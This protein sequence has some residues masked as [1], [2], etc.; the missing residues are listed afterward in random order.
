[1]MAMKFDALNV[2]SYGVPL[3]PRDWPAGSFKRTKFG[4]QVLWTSEYHLYSHEL[5]PYRH[6]GD[7]P[8]DTILELLQKENRPLCASA[9]LLALGS[10]A[11]NL[12]EHP[13]SKP[14][15][16]DRQLAKFM[17]TYSKLPDWVD[18]EQLRNGQ[19]VF[20]AYLPVV[21]ISLYYR[22]LVAGFSIPKIA[23]VIK[24]T[25]YLSPPARPDQ[26][27][28]RLIDTGE[29]TSACCGGLG[30][31]AILPGG[32]GWKTALHVRV[33]HGKIRYALLQ[34]KG[35]KRWDTN[36][37]GVPINQEDM[38]ATLLAFSVNVLFGI[39]FMSG[40]SLSDKERC[41]YLALWRYIGWLLG[42]ETDDNDETRTLGQPSTK[43]LPV[44]DPCGPGRGSRPDCIRHSAAKLQSMIWHLLE[45][46][47]SSTEIAHHLLKITDRRPPSMQFH[48]IPDSFYKN[49]LYYLRS[50]NC[51]RLIGDPL[52]DALEL[53]FHPNRWI[54][55]KIAI[56]SQVIFWMLRLYTAA[57]MRVPFIR[58]WMVRQHTRGLKAFHNRWLESHPSKMARAFAKNEKP[59][60]LADDDGH[61]KNFDSKFHDGKNNVPSS[62]NDSAAPSLCP[63]AMAAPPVA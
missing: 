56:K 34:R 15:D 35:E 52:A 22:S 60:V 16:A 55:L 26:A 5:E 38:S 19:E 30:V 40:M 6:I 47:S 23:K 51:R 10:N 12:C 11:K 3:D 25:A 31:E 17:D 13:N 48:K 9:D 18:V 4:Q 53:P 7:G 63:F 21:S 45:P 14:T 8:V 29:L 43:A 1:M 50:Y 42:V 41:D 27:L 24:S 57:G 28:Q 61:D 54:R 46:D 32:I 33:L 37:Y 49:E 58:R 36:K 39:H 62:P 44:L 2:K 20:L 59:S